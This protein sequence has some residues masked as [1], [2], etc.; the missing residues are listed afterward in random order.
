MEM[1]KFCNNQSELFCKYGSEIS[2]ILGLLQ[3][4]T[5]VFCELINVYM[6]T[7]QDSVANSIVNFVTLKV[8]M[9]MPKMYFMALHDNPLKEVTEQHLKLV[10]RG[11]RALSSRTFFHKIARIIYKFSRALYVSVIFYFIPFGV[12][13]V[14]FYMTTVKNEEHHEVAEA[15]HAAAH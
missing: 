8:I 5:A 15:A 4:L 13:Y 12:L 11:P 7:F 9:A 14:S 10:N 1:M 2:Y 3:F 6:L